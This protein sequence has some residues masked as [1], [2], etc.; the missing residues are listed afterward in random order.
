MKGVH[1]VKKERLKQLHG[2]SKNIVRKF[3]IFS[4]R[5]CENGNK[6][7]GDILCGAMPIQ[8]SYVKD[9]LIYEL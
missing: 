1:Q 6:M 9:E 3:K 8:Y 7:S 2:K 5:H 4:I